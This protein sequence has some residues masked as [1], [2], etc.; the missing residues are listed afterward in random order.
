M[1]YFALSGLSRIS[2]L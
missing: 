1:K 2:S